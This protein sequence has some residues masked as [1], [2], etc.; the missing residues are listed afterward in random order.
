MKEL[1]S[2]T[3]KPC[4]HLQSNGN[5]QGA[6]APPEWYLLRKTEINTHLLNVY[7]IPQASA[8]QAAGGWEQGLL[9]IKISKSPVTKRWCFKK[10][11]IEKE[12]CS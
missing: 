11:K 2:V 7:Y 6:L 9:V 1:N 3:V 5:G 12:F 8:T 4:S 10:N